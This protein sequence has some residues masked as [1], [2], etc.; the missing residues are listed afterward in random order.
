[1]DRRV[2]GIGAAA[3]LLCSVKAAAQPGP[4]DGPRR[5]PERAPA[6]SLIVLLHG[7]G[8]NGAD[9]IGLAPSFQPYAPNAAFAAPNGPYAIDGGYSWFT[10]QDQNRISEHDR[11]ARAAAG[12]G[13]A[14]DAFLDAELAR[15]KLAPERLILVGFSQGAS[16][17]LNTGLRRKVLPAAIVAFSGANLAPAGLPRTGRRPPVL[18]IQGDQ[19]PRVS[20]AAQQQAMRVLKDIGAPAQAHMLS[21]LGH[22]IDDRGIRLA[23]ELIRSVTHAL[24]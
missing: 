5:P 13:P 17:A 20:P 7:F 8:S 12:G 15:Y 18:L 24:A 21:G 22:D 16:T 4:R 19:D 9:M 6:R 1:M 14:L 10:P 23:G 2:F 11:Q 3:T